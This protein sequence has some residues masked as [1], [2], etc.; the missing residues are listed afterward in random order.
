M[1]ITKTMLK[2]ALRAAEEQN[3]L[4]EQIAHELYGCSFNELDYD[5]Q[6]EVMYEA[7]DRMKEKRGWM[8]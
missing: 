6:E 4:E 2:E 3:N 1:K 8:A 5:D 7:S